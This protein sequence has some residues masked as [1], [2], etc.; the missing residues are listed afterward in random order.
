MIFID[1]KR[2]CGHKEQI[3]I[4]GYSGRIEDI[5]DPADKQVCLGSV[6]NAENKL[7]LPCLKSLSHEERKKELDN[8]G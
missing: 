5:A 2:R 7:C 6:E 3:G 1:I 4:A 8:G